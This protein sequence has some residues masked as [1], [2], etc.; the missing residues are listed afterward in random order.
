MKIGAVFPTTEI[1]DD[2]AVLREWAQTAEGLGYDYILTYDHVLGAQHAR[3]EPAL[4]GPYNEEHPFHEPFVLFSWLAGLTERIE[5]CTGVLILPQRQTALVAKQAAELAVLSGNRLRLGF[6]TGWN[7]V[8]YESLGVP[9]E[10]RGARFDEQ[11]DV[12]EALWREPLLDYTGEFHRIDRANI[13]PRPSQPIPLWF[14]AMSGVALARAAKRGDG[15]IFATR[16]K[17]LGKM[18]AQAQEK[19]AAE[20]READSFGYEASL[21]FSLGEQAWAEDLALWRESGGT[22][23]ALRAMNTG[24]ALM[25]LENVDYGGPAG[26]IEALETFMKA[27]RG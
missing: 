25:G 22:H 6:G 14:G 13:L 4:T 24:N 18:L 17:F 7:Y 21:D 12:L 27:V 3:R 15:L 2:P 19:V 23:I 26:Y 1:G 16:P 20:G 10:R 5:L 9:Y 11:L 8:E